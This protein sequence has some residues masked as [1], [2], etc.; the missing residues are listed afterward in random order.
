MRHEKKKALAIMQARMGS[1]RLPGKVLKEV[2]GESLLAYELSRLA[3]CK[4]I[5]T[6]VVATSTEHEDDAIEALC[7][8]LGVA[9]FRGSLAD[10]LDRYHR[11]AQEYPDHDIIVRVTGD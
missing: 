9:C 4:T 6:I 5:D 7:K 11:C 3:A 2:N 10:V 8:E 1:T